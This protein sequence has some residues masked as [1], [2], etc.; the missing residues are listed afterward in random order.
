MRSKQEI[1]RD[2]EVA[3][4][5]QALKHPDW[6]IRDIAYAADTRPATARHYLRH[7][8]PEIYNAREDAHTR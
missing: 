7:H 3:I 5:Y 2:T 6:S 8:A 4:Y 1:P